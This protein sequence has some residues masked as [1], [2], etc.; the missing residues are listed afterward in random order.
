MMKAYKKRDIMII[1]AITASCVTCLV[2]YHALFW[3][4][5]AAALHR[6]GGCSCDCGIPLDDDAGSY[7]I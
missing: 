5:G 7:E 1:S 3:M 6:K 2:L 4:C